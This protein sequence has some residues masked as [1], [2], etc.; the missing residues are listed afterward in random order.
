MLYDSCGLTSAA[1]AEYGRTVWNVDLE[2]PEMINPRTHRCCAVL[3]AAAVLLGCAAS[4]AA[5]EAK[6]LTNL[7]GIAEGTLTGLDPV[8]QLR[9]PNEVRVIGPMQQYDI[10][11]TSILQLSF[12]FPRVVIETDTGVVIGPY[13]AFLGIAEKLWITTDRGT[14]PIL[15]TSVRAIALHGRAL[16]PVPRE[17]MGDRFLS[18]PEILAAAPL[19]VEPCENCAVTTPTTPPTSTT[20]SESSVVWNSITPEAAVEEPSTELPWWIGVL[21]LG[22]LVIVLY[23]LGSSSS[24]T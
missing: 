10:P 18:E 13:S 6:V 21:A 9:T 11:L 15:V 17:W 1:L 8:I 24:S 3:I 12:D 2:V 16:Q 5:T 14:F 4:L 20:S 23:I 19:Q 22:A 7:G